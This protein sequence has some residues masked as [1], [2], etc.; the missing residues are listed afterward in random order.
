MVLVFD[1]VKLLYIAKSSIA[2]VDRLQKSISDQGIA[3]VDGILRTVGI[4]DSLRPLIALVV[5][6]LEGMAPR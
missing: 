1:F 3:L 2:F 6:L 5:R 4:L